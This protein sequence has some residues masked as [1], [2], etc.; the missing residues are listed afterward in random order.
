MMIRC[1]QCKEEF[2][3]KQLYCVNC[4]T[5]TRP[6]WIWEDDNLGFHHAV[7]LHDTE[8]MGGPGGKYILVRVVPCRRH[9]FWEQ[10]NRWMQHI[11]EKGPNGRPLITWWTPSINTKKW[12]P[13]MFIKIAIDAIAKGRET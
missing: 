1:W 13:V 7:Y 12:R 8:P 4:A 3:P 6:C 2:H 10:Q 11:H 9:Q 5:L